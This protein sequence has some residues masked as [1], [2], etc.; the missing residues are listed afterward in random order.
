V[1]RKGNANKTSSPSEDP[2]QNPHEIRKTFYRYQPNQEA[3]R[4]TGAGHNHSKQGAKHVET[5]P[6]PTTRKQSL[7]QPKSHPAHP[8][9]HKKPTQERRTRSGRRKTQLQWLHAPPAGPGIEPIPPF[10]RTPHQNQP[11]GQSERREIQGLWH[12]PRGPEEI[13]DPARSQESVGGNTHTSCVNQSGGE[14]AK[15]QEGANQANRK[16][17]GI[18][19]VRV[20]TVAPRR[21]RHKNQPI[22][23]TVSQPVDP[24]PNSATRGRNQSGKATWSGSKC[25]VGAVS[26]GKQKKAS[27]GHEY[28]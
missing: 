6:K 2:L 3:K 9:P 15:P 1:G 14:N 12:A 18:R 17:R 16:Q 10:R 23:P 21:G 7:P 22:R 20:R 8:P 24:G 4:P 13:E 27:P 25:Q 5:Q 11:K 19:R 26:I 28:T